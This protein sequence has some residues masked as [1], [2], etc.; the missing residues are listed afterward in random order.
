LPHAHHLPHGLV[1]RDDLDGADAVVPSLA[2]PELFE[3]L[4]I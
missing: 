3:L 1:P 2:A 4:G